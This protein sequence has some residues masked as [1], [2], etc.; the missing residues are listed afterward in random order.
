MASL[1]CGVLRGGGNGANALRWLFAL[2]LFGG[3]VMD[4]AAAHATPRESFVAGR[5]AKKSDAR[6]AHFQQGIDKAKLLL[7]KDSNS[8]EGLFWLAVNM[9]AEALERGKMSALPVVPKMERLLLKLD[10][11]DPKYEEAGAARVL[12]RLYHQA[13]AVISVGSSDKARKYLERALSLA[14]T[15]PG[16]QAFAADFLLEKGDEERAKKLASACLKTLDATAARYGDEGK[17]WR[18]LAQ[19]VIDD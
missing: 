9:G 6:K 18:K 5:A 2:T 1:R 10:G 15:H 17:E 12:G 8:S 4:M 3:V 11:L 7:T 14:P 19:D 16:N 13:P